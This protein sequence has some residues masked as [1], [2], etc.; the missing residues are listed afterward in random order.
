LKKKETVISIKT[1]GHSEDHVKQKH[2]F[3]ALQ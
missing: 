1:S 3:L 2:L